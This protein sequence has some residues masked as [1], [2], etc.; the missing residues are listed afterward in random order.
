M[1]NIEYRKLHNGATRTM[2]DAAASAQRCYGFHDFLLIRED[3]GIVDIP[4]GGPGNT[5]QFATPRNRH[6]KKLVP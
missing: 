4:E 2:T 3:S 5:D 1:I 6:K